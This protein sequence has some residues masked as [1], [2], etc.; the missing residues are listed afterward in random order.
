MLSIHSLI[1]TFILFLEQKEG[2]TSKEI[3]FFPF[4]PKEYNSMVKV[5]IGSLVLCHLLSGAPAQ[6]GE[7]PKI[8]KILGTIAEINVGKIPKIYEDP[9]K[10]MAYRVMSDELLIRTNQGAIYQV[11][12]NACMAVK[13]SNDAEVD[14]VFKK[15]KTSSLPAHSETQAIEK[16]DMPSVEET[17]SLIS[18]QIHKNLIAPAPTPKKKEQPKSTPA[19]VIKEEVK[20]VE[21]IAPPP[22]QPL[23]EEKKEVLPPPPPPKEEVKE[24]PPSDDKKKGLFDYITE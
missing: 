8:V 24:V 22:S 3:C 17:T 12:V 13:E 16:Q 4:K 2:L 7:A 18:D 15:D 10:R 23:P 19:P 14:Q 11:D 9:E 20:K 1:L 6:D 21:P 5:K